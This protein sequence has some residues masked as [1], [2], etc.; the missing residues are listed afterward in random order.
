M[1][2]SDKLYFVTV[3]HEV[4]HTELSELFQNWLECRVYFSFFGIPI[5]MALRIQKFGGSSYQTCVLLK[6]FTLL[7]MLPALLV[8]SNLVSR[9]AS[10]QNI[11]QLCTNIKSI[12]RILVD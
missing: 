11:N 1:S 6:L 5:H 9:Q 4:W 12:N 10:L 8:I 3:P 7:H 2:F